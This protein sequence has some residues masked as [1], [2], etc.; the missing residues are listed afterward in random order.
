MIDNVKS[1]IRSCAQEEIHKIA[2]E[3]FIKRVCND[4]AKTNLKDKIVE[5][6]TERICSAF[7]ED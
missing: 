7:E 4:L 3:E 1:A 6:F 5:S 2:D